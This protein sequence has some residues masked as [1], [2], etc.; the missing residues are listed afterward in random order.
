MQ[1]KLFLLNYNNCYI[2]MMNI[3]NIYSN[4]NFLYDF[5]QSGILLN[6]GQVEMNGAEGYIGSAGG[7]AGGS[8]FIETKSLIGKGIFS[9]NGGSYNGAGGR[10]AIYTNTSVNYDN[11]FQVH[12]YDEAIPGL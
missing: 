5:T 12:G 6:D 1:N 3:Y 4:L 8:L 11:I 2:Q 9:C 10:I 7:G